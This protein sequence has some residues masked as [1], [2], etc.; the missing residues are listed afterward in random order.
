MISSVLAKSL[1]RIQNLKSKH[2]DRRLEIV[3][4]AISGARVVKFYGW[5]RAF[6][7]RIASVRAQEVVQLTKFAFVRMLTLALSTATPSLTVRMRFDDPPAIHRLL[8]YSSSTTQP[9][10]Q[11][12]NRPPILRRLASFY[13][14][15]PQRAG[16]AAY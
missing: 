14:V 10:T 16:A 3:S 7:A 4:E 1:K 15:H 2:A 6:A 8:A 13:A 12:I 11:P 5:E 9:R